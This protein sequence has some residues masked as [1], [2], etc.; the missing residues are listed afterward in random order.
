MVPKLLTSV[1]TGEFAVAPAGAL[2]IRFDR[3]PW[4]YAQ[5]YM[6]PPRPWLKSV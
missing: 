1:A 6:L 4:A 2:R 3:I 5:G